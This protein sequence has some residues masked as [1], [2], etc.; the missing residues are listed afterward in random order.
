ML[1][2]RLE[3]RVVGFRL[4]EGPRMPGVLLYQVLRAVLLHLLVR[5]NVF[6]CSGVHVLDQRDA[7]S[8]TCASINVL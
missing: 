3:E 8:S 7:E 1:C 5:G 4:S 2:N 6:Q